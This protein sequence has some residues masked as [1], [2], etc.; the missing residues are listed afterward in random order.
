MFSLSSNYK[1]KHVDGQHY[2]NA[3]LEVAIAG[4]VFKL[5]EFST[6][7]MH[8]CAHYTYVHDYITTSPPSNKKKEEEEE[9]KIK[10][11]SE[12]GKAN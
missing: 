9:I 8:A 2:N 12:E 7:S 3:S 5:C 11:Q 6:A 10:E 4:F 1:V